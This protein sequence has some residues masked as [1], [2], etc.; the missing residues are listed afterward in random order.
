MVTC[1]SNVTIVPWSGIEVIKRVPPIFY[2]RDSTLSNLIFPF[3][4]SFIESNELQS[5]MFCSDYQ[6][7][8]VSITVTMW[9][10]SINSVIY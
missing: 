4:F 6:W 5:E 3:T 9:P 7:P 2:A 1:T 8:D 10:N